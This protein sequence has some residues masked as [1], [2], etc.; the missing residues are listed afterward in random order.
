MGCFSGKSAQAVSVKIENT[1]NYTK[2]NIVRN[3]SKDPSDLL[4]DYLKVLKRS[5][6]SQKLSFEPSCELLSKIV[7]NVISHY[8][9]EK[10]RRIKKDNKKFLMF[11]GKFKGIDEVMKFL[12]FK[13]QDQEWVYVESLGKSHAQMKILDLNIA[14][15][16]LR[17]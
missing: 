3:A 16:K 6:T 13:D 5:I 8:E 12:G 15:N 17:N 14:Y 10:Y 7:R 11:L 2:E 4:T 1:P 9:D